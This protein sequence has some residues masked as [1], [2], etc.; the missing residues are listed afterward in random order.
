MP[1]A[2][3]ST[4]AAQAIS[5]GLSTT[6]APDLPT[7]EDATERVTCTICDDS[8]D[9]SDST[10]V[11]YDVVCHSCAPDAIVCEHCGHACDRN[12]AQ[13]VHTP[14]GNETW[15]AYCADEYASAC[16]DCG[17]L[18]PNN[19]DAFTAVIGRG[20]YESYVCRDCLNSGDYFQ[21]DHCGVWFSTTSLN[22]ST[23]EDYRGEALTL[24]DSCLEDDYTTCRRCGRVC[25]DYDAECID[26]DYL[27]PDCADSYRDSMDSP[28][29]QC[30]GHTYASKFYNVG[31]FK[32]CGER[33]GLYLGVELE[34]VA[35]NSPGALATHI[36]EA[37]SKYGAACVECKRDS[38]L[39][40]YGVEVA[41]QPG[42]PAWH[43]GG[44][45]KDIIATCVED[46]AKSHDAG[47]C[48]LHVHVSRKFFNDSGR[49]AY[50]LD[51]LFQRFASRWVRFSRRS[52]YDIREWARMG[53]GGMVG[54]RGESTS[55]K[56]D[57]WQ[58]EKC[59]RYQCV[60]TQNYNTIE[61]RLWRGTL[62]L[63]TF[64]ATIEATAALCI[65][66]HTLESCPEYVEALTWSGLKDEMHA[67]LD[68][69]SI[70]SAELDSYLTARGL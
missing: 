42:T 59:T 10:R 2:T 61:I 14:N 27:C 23:Y 12:D 30:Y 25:R 69:Y 33:K 11:G 65:I 45:W 31:G 47:S 9:V 49:G 17:K 32:D 48:G 41:S 54:Y 3:T 5:A 39:G 6:E 7:T 22:I 58:N 70:S 62:N 52:E 55:A 46:G 16:E 56:I 35:D 24:C 63:E 8:I 40:D 53:S 44:L 34:T 64:Y 60:N 57:A 18:Y 28:E 50:V 19:S 38:S 1:E 29:L 4:T 21:C 66:A 51:R 26:G 13:T 15:C 68:I 43:M 20:G 37:A 67:A 36:V